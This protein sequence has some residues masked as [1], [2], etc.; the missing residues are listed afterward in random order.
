MVPIT[1][2]YAFKFFSDRGLLP[3]EP[4]PGP[5]KPWKS[6]HAECGKVVTPQW[7]SIQQGGSGCKYCSGN[8]VDADDAE[9]LFR[10]LGAIPL[11]PYPGGDKPWKSKHDKCGK[12]I[13]PRY[14]GVKGGQGVCRHCTGRYVDPTEAKEYF[15]S[16]GLTP[17][18]EYPGA[19][20]GWKSIH[21]VCGKEVTPYYGYVKSGGIGCNYCSGL[22]PISPKAARELFLS[23]GF[24]PLEA[25]VNTKTPVRAIH[26]VCGREV[27]PSYGSLRNG[28]GC[29]YCSVGGI[30]L[31][32]P[33]FLY[34]MTHKELGAH[35]VGIGGYSSS[36]NRIEQHQKQGWDLYRTLDFKTAELAYLVEQEVL[37]WIRLDLGLL[38][39]LA[40]EQMPQGGHTETVDASEIDLPAIWA[41]VEE[42]SKVIK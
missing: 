36:S 8:F 40:L 10:S 41:K 35:K 16:R 18:V 9:K 15:E 29:K 25:F 39:Y 21:N 33:G 19:N 20:T 42:A 12:E 38:Q 4:F 7:N 30:N 31:T 37:N 23:R 27:K 13:F 3:Q 34:L 24:K 17:L 26:K 6:I 5:L 32:K 14:S 1:Q 2:E 22:A 28:G 11:V